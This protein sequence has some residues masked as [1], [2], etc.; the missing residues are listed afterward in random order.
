[1]PEADWFAM[2][3]AVPVVAGVIVIV[4]GASVLPVAFVA[5]TV[6]TV[7]PAAVGVPVINPEALIVRPAG[8]TGVPKIAKLVAPVATTW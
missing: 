7:V 1:M 2:T 6:T 5:R 4:S 3:G 8:K